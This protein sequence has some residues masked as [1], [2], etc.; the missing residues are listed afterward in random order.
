MKMNFNARNWYWLV[1]GNPGVYSSAAN[2][3]VPVTDPIY[4]AWCDAGFIPARINS[5]AEIWP[6]VS[7]FLPAW[8]FDGAS[9]AQPAVGAYMPAQLSN[10]AASVRYDKEVAGITVGGAALATDRGSQAM[11]NGAFN[12]A[13]RDSGF[14]TQWKT[15]GGAFQRVDAP[16]IIALATAV[17][18]HVAVCF[19][20]ES[21]VAAG[22]AAGTIKTLSDIDAA[23]AQI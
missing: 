5:E 1:A 2:I 17:G 20:K 13:M 12:M 19:A 11:I 21:E 16:T 7:S 10:Y 9:F 18:A 14:S 3:Y 23:F 22:I 6:Y 4:R 15:S 8:L